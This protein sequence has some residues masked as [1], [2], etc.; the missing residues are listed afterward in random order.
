MKQEY[1]N[2]FLRRIKKTESCWLWMNKDGT[3]SPDTYGAFWTGSD[4]RH[5]AHR[6]S[7]EIHKGPIPEGKLIM[8]SCDNRRC[9]NPEHLFIGTIKEN[10]LDAVSKGRH[11]H[12]EREPNSKLTDSAVRYIR[13][14]YRFRDPVFNLKN[15]AKRFRVDESLISRVVLGKCWKHIGGRTGE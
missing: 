8:H 2:R 3:D 12:G 11:S 5:L 14:V 6:L 4:D 15:L 10:I 9:V 7:Y 13:K 1:I